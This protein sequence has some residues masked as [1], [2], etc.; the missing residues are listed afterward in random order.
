MKKESIGHD[1]GFALS[2]SVEVDDQTLRVSLKFTNNNPVDRVLL[3]DNSHKDI[4]F[5]NLIIRDKSGERL[6]PRERV[7]RRALFLDYE[8]HP[9]HPGESWIYVIEGSIQEN[10]VVFPGCAYYMSRNEVYSIRCRY[11]LYDLDR[12]SNT[13]TIILPA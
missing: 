12:I 6:L 7:H 4:E 10:K 3:F 8:R 13:E 11:I 9:L 1:H 5:G 2:I